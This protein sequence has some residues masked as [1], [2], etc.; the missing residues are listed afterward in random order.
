MC[1]CGS[2]HNDWLAFRMY[3]HS[4]T[5]IGKNF[6]FFLDSIE[7]NLNRLDMYLLPIID[8]IVTGIIS[9]QQFTIICR[10]N[11]LLWIVLISKEI[12]KVQQIIVQL[13]V[14][15]LQYFNWFSV[16][17]LG[18]W[19]GLKQRDVFYILLGYS[20]N[21]NRIPPQYTRFVLDCIDLTD[22]KYFQ[23][24]KYQMTKIAIWYVLNSNV[25]VS[26]CRMWYCHCF[27]KAIIEWAVNINKNADQL[28]QWELNV[29]QNGYLVRF[30]PL[31]MHRCNPW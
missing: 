29:K 28:D 18:I 11:V 3:L 6:F 25:F 22:G 24:W 10:D 16:V 13:F 31:A 1:A 30:Y 27:K 2:I 5:K 23:S 15:R 9:F 14:C 20:L 8:V 12:K 26:F 7:S 4:L 17:N 19:N 21:R